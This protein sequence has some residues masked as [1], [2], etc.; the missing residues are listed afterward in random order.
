MERSTENA[1]YQPDFND[2]PNEVNVS[3]ENKV[4]PSGTNLSF[5][6]LASLA[7]LPPPRPHRSA[8][9]GPR[10]SPLEPDDLS[11]PKRPLPVP[12]GR[13][14]R[15][16]RSSH[17]QTSGSERVS[18]AAS[19]LEHKVAGLPFRGQDPAGTA[20]WLARSEH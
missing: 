3:H 9:N 7:N 1:I 16:E 6:P 13:V 8:A 2:L 17:L 14:R 19:D 18:A 10:L 5:P 4:D 11:L 20:K 15:P 12:P